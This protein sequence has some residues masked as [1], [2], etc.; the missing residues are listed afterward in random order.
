[1]YKFDE[2]S[3]KFKNILKLV[4][5]NEHDDVVRKVD[6]RT[7]PEFIESVK[8]LT[9]ATGRKVLVQGDVQSGKTDKIIELIKHRTDDEG[10]FV[11]FL[12]GTKTNLRKQN[13]ERIEKSLREFYDTRDKRK[14]II[15][16]KMNTT[17]D[18]ID[19][20]NNH[21][22][23]E[24]SYVTIEIKDVKQLERIYKVAK[25]L[26]DNN[27]KILFID[28]EGDEASL[29]NKTGDLIR[30]ITELE[31]VQYFSITATPFKNLHDY[32]NEYDQFVVLDA[33][34][35]YKG[36]KAY[37][38]RYDIISE[39]DTTDKIIENS[40]IRW[41]NTVTD[42]GFEK[43]QILFNFDL[44]TDVH[45]DIENKIDEFF[46]KELVNLH[47]LSNPDAGLKIAGYKFLQEFDVMRIYVSN[48][49]QKDKLREFHE[50]EMNKG[51]YIIIGGGTLSR[52]VTYENLLVEVMTN[53]PKEK[54]N[55]GTLLQRARWFGYKSTFE[56]ISIFITEDIWDALEQLD[57]LNDWTRTY[58]LNTGYKEKFSEENHTKLKL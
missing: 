47:P 3:K 32:E 11:I 46:R 14:Y 15:S 20:I 6:H 7:K 1:M 38:Q 5:E 10:W 18:N 40:M 53:A 37:K 21:L 19:I 44:S 43:S 34:D 31:G 27:K 13:F 4:Y 22:N 41:A 30:K 54:M 49:N 26:S 17:S 29:A 28:D 45:S 2:S 57:K 36:L 8:K 48:S 33:G 39:N 16:T 56:D 9:D 50:S 12:A 42:K 25:N 51:H 24:G 55:P 52:G 58:K 35:D 23:S